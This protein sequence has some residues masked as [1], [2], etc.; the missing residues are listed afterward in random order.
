MTELFSEMKLKIHMKS[1]M[2]LEY[3]FN[4]VTLPVHVFTASGHED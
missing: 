2:I 4:Q 3:Q 1:K